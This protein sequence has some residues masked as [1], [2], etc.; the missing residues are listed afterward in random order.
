MEF[1]KGDG[2]RRE[3]WLER[4]GRPFRN[5][6]R[7]PRIKAPLKRL[8][9]GLLD[10]LPGDRLVSRFPG[11]ET[12]RLAA[13]YRQVVWNPEEYEAF[14]RAVRPGSIALDIGANLG[15]YTLLLAQWVGPAG[16]VHAFEP[17]PASRQG[18]LRHV[19][20]NAL[21]SRVDVHPE[22]VA[23]ADGVAR[24]AA[25]GIQGDNRL[26]GRT[27]P[28]GIEVRT[29]TLDA[30]CAA[31][32]IAPGFVKVDVEGAELD[33]LRGARATIAAAGPA[34]E[35]YMEFHPHL[36]GDFGYARADLEAELRRQGL[37]PERLDGRPDP[38]SLAGVC[39]RLRPCAS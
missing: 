8:Y 15:G 39:L 36:W 3:G 35:L 1:G 32:G 31:H 5:R 23:G 34:L 9:E 13:A 27:A 21:E 2:F 17:A 26:A 28:G 12:V 11:G 33:L 22:A 4:A 16:R 19:A 18:L 6:L 37:R 20:L 7:D 10:A 25:S 14:R 24:F 29:T 30:F 38:W